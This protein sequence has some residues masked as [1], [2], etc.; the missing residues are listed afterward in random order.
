[1][2]LR[3]SPDES[4]RQILRRGLLKMTVWTPWA[5]LNASEGGFETRPYG[6]GGPVISRSPAG[7]T[8]RE[9]VRGEEESGLGGDP[10]RQ[11]RYPRWPRFFVGDSSE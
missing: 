5:F 7:L 11:V 6:D 2:S 3:P 8:S 10:Q 9:H 4:P 1:M